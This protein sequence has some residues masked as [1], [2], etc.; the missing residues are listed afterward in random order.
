MLLSIILPAYNVEKYIRDCLESIECQ[1]NSTIEIIVVDDGSTDSTRSIIHGFKSIKYFYQSNAGQS[2]ARNFGLQC[3]KGK[4]VWFVDSDDILVDGAI[5]KIIDVLN[6]QENNNKDVDILAFD[7][8]YF[9]DSESIDFNSKQLNYIRP[10]FNSDIVSQDDF[11]NISVRNGQYFVQPCHYVFRRELMY[12]I[13]F[14]EGIIYEDNLFTTDIFCGGKRRIFVLNEI[15]YKR[16][17]RQG[18]TVTSNFNKRNVDSFKVVLDE[19]IS[20]REKYAL[21]VNVMYLDKYISTI[22]DSY[23]ISLLRV[24][25]NS[26]AH[27]IRN[28]QK[29]NRVSSNLLSCKTILLGI[30]PSQIYKLMRE[31]K[32]IL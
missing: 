11:F 26:L 27:R 12:D 17:V 24:N 31:V 28:L 10:R 23:Y 7:G 30:M 4:Y 22:I 6:N 13:Q 14:F 3:S 32:K 18:S 15:I 2:K 1:I 25:K 21:H 16:R 29:L 9:I 8:D 5:E 19:L 20:R